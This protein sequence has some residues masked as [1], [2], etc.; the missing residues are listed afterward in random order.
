MLIIEGSCYLGMP[1][2]IGKTTIVDMMKKFL[3]IEVDT[4][5]NPITNSDYL[6][7][8]VND[9]RNYDFFVK[10]KL[11]IVKEDKLMYEHFGR[12][13]VIT[14]DFKV[15]SGIKNFDDFLD[16]C[17]CAI[18]NSFM[19]HRYLRYSKKLT[20][21]DRELVRKWWDD[22]EYTELNA[23][24]VAT[25]LKKLSE[26]LC[27]HYNGR[28]V[29]VLVDEDDYPFREA[30]EGMDAWSETERVLNF[31]AGII[32][33]IF[34]NNRVVEQGLVTG[35][36]SC[37]PSTAYRKYTNVDAMRYQRLVEVFF[38]WKPMTASLQFIG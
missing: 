32:T 11:D 30:F 1:E 33:S 12:H 27:T 29:F 9:T 23:T 14:V 26:Y 38:L 28:R 8:P 20:D 10:H 16:V 18:H 6:E 4:N 35:I 13:P 17:R 21:E 15:G 24:V 5:G 3:E 36:H 2:G 7:E 37:F 22:S 34:K 19:E 31:M 25:S